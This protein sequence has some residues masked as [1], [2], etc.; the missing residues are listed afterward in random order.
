MGPLGFRVHT[1]GLPIAPKSQH[2][3]MRGGKFPSPAVG[4][5]SVDIHRGFSVPSAAAVRWVMFPKLT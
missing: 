1:F 4:N 5:S 3:I 2:R